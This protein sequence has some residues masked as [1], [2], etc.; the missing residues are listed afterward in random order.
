MDF[1]K[2]NEQNE[3]FKSLEKLSIKEVQS[4]SISVLR[5]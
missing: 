4:M 2:E 3:L 1:S 5:V